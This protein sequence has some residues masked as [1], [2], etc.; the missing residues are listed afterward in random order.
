M[1]TW[2]KVWCDG[3]KYLSKYLVFHYFCLILQKCLQKLLFDGWTWQLNMI[4]FCTIFW[5]NLG[6]LPENSTYICSR[7]AVRHLNLQRYHVVVLYKMHFLLHMMSIFV[8]FASCITKKTY[9]LLFVGNVTACSGKMVNS[10]E[11]LRS[12]TIHS[13]TK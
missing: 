4:F 2:K 6:F 1:K 9:W 3:S 11:D 7:A 10:I 12:S 8:L 5:K 13:R